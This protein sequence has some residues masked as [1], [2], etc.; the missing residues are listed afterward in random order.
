M[1]NFGKKLI[2]LLLTLALLASMM[3]AFAA[4]TAATSKALP[5]DV[6]SDAWY[7]EAANFVW[8]NGYMQGTNLGFEPDGTVTRAQLFT[9]LYRIQGSPAVTSTSSFADV[10]ADAWYAKAAAWAKQAGITDGTPKGFEGGTPIQRQQ[11]AKVLADYAALNGKTLKSGNL[12]KFSD[13]AQIASWAK[14]AVTMMAGSGIMAGSN[15]KADPTGTVTRAQLAQFLYNYSKATEQVTYDSKL[16]PLLLEG[17]MGIETTTMT[18]ALTDTTTYRL[19]QWEYVAGTYE[20][21][22]VVVCRT[23][24]GE[25]NAA[26]STALAMEFFNPVA[27]IDQ[28]TSGGHDPALHTYDI[29]LGKQTFDGSAWVS[30]QSAK[31]AGVDYKAIE[32]LGVYAY[33]ASKKEFTQQ[34]YYPGDETLLAA[35]NAVKSSYTKGKIVEGNIDTCDCWNNQIDRM[36]Y[37]YEKFGSSCE[38]METN[39]AAQICKSYSVPFLGI[40]ILSNT[41]I[42]GESFDW[43]TGEACQTYTLSVAKQYITSYLKTASSSVT[44]NT[45]TSSLKSQSY[46]KTLRPFMI[47]GAMN[48]ETKTMIAALEN[49]KTYTLGQYTYVAGTYHGYPM[50]I[51]RTEQGLANAGASTALGISFFNP[52]AIINQGTSGGHDPELHTGDIVVGSRTVNYCAWKT[53]ASAKGAGADY[54]AFEMNGVY[55]YDYGAGEFTQSVYHNGDTALIE[56]ANAAKTTVTDRKIKNGTIGTSNE[57]NCQIDRILYLNKTVGTSSEDME[58][59]AAAQIAQTYNV[60]FLGIRILSDNAIYEEE[61]DIT[62]GVPCQTYALSVAAAY[63]DANLK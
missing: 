28:G 2:V 33:D 55:A 47:Q 44:A 57:W 13:A 34:V 37:Y 38:E 40:R 54:T 50:V 39:A 62:T 56:A 59:D 14:I 8:Q 49:A 52:A 17:A 32:M 63:I 15:G 27:V 35:A 24:Q 36:L 22:P 58:T 45:Q 23:E 31:G 18:A 46:D 30:T 10:P 7:A 43:K 25:S 51:C 11:I 53:A 26:A 61:F 6:A 29:V 12:D 9:T 1:K 42:Y 21:Y 60:P 20:G 41:G 3:T 4:G 48:A 5:A 19:G 16:R